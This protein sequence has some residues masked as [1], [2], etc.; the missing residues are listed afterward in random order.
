MNYEAARPPRPPHRRGVGPLGRDSAFGVGLRRRGSERPA[1]V[2][3]T[4][5]YRPGVPSRTYEVLT[6]ALARYLLDQC[7]TWHDVAP[8]A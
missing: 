2:Y 8:L 1:P 3:H 5:R 4:I 6:P 7:H